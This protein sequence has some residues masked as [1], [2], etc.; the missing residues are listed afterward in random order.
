MSIVPY[1][2]NNEVVYHD[3]KHRILV[4][5]NNQ[6]NTIQLL[7]AAPEDGNSESL[8][9]RNA[10]LPERK[11]ELCCPNCGVELAEYLNLKKTSEFRRQNSNSLG[12]GRKSEVRGS[13]VSFRDLVPAG[14]MHNDYFKL[15]GSL[16]QGKSNAI[17]SG[18]SDSLPSDVFNQGY[19][20]R[21]F[22]KIPPYVLGSGAH[23]QVY[24][25]MHV[26]KNIQLGVFAVKRI[27]VGDHTTYLDQVLNEVLILYE[28]SVQGANENNLI[29]YNH[30]WMELGDLKDLET[31]FLHETAVSSESDEKVPYVYILQQYCDG[32]HLESLIANNFQREKYMSPKEKLE[33]ER[34]KRRDK[35]HGTVV[36]EAETLWLSDLEV[37]KFFRDIANGVHYLHSHGILHRDLKPSNCLLESRYI[38]EPLSSELFVRIADFDDAVLKMPKVLVSD[39]GEG[40][41][42]DKQFLADQSVYIDDSLNSERRGNTGTIEFTDPRLWMYATLEPSA[43][44]GTKPKLAYSFTYNSDIYSLGMILCYLCVGSLPFAAKISDLNDPEQIRNDIAQWFDHLTPELFHSWFVE[45]SVSVKGIVSE[46]LEDFEILIYMMLKGRGDG[47][48][49]N[50]SAVMDHL[51]K[52]KWSR[53]VRDGE[54]KL[55]EVTITEVKKAQDPIEDLDTASMDGD[56]IDLTQEE[57]VP[58]NFDSNPHSKRVLKVFSSTS[59]ELIIALVYILNIAGLEYVEDGSGVVKMVKFFNL[60]CLAGEI[61]TRDSVFQTRLLL[62]CTLLSCITAYCSINL[63]IW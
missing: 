54:R 63:I 33:S 29:R 14:F 3:P 28:L 34:Q 36:K 12:S 10:E 32:G 20:E 49:L 38:H 61:A 51:D 62:F 57:A 2:A 17:A 27:S 47:K 46:C 6:D 15:L 48:K 31:I 18:A 22:L 41:F 7:T 37:W 16:P 50:S 60:A 24:K 58:S 1:N 35:K 23:A 5:H 30:V 40:K 55:S 52:M 9:F 44:T 8:T 45:N 19:F 13:P 56:A 25:V 21:F 39:F 43:R 4:V 11:Q 26:L 53:F 59:Q 42:I